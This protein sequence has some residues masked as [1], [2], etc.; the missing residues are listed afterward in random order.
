MN[1]EKIIIIIVSA[2]VAL[3]GF[4]YWHY[5][6]NTPVAL[7]YEGSIYKLDRVSSIIRKKSIKSIH[8][9]GS[10][11]YI[12]L[13]D[14]KSHKLDFLTGLRSYEHIDVLNRKYIKMPISAMEALTASQ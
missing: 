9:D 7:R 4:G 8:D 2:I 11:W 13:E 14:G 3:S 1:K 12:N 6:Y 10:I 5:Y